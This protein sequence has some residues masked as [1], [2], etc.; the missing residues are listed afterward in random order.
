MGKSRLLHELAEALTHLICF[1]SP[2]HQDSA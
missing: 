2:H 1:C